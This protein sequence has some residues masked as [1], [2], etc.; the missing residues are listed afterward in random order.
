MP[1]AKHPMKRDARFSYIH[2][3]DDKSVARN[4]GAQSLAGG[5]VK[6]AWQWFR[7]HDDLVL[8]AI[9]RGTYQWRCHD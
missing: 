6:R 9:V 3:E 7:R 2:L 1:A 8:L 4:N 5:N